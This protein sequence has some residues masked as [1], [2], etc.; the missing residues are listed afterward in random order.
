LP[1]DPAQALLEQAA[2]AQLL[3]VGSRGSHG[4]HRFV[5]SMIR[6]LTHSSVSMFALHHA[7]C[8]VAIVHG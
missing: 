5:P 2:T 8:P 1:E 6:E 4:F 7:P 3:V